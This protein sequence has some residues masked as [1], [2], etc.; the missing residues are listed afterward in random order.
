MHDVIV[1]E[2]RFKEAE[3]GMD[4]QGGLGHGRFMDRIAGGASA[5]V[6]AESR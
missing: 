5:G 1:S 6:R 4:E 2:A 3:R